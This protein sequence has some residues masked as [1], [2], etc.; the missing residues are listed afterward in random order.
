MT[1]RAIRGVVLALAILTLTAVPASAATRELLTTF[2]ALEEPAG[3]AVDLETGNV[4]VVE[5]KAHVIDVFGATGGAPADGVPAQIPIV[6]NEFSRGAPAGVAVDNACYEHEPRLT[7]RACEEYDPAY[8]DVYIADITSLSSTGG[9]KQFKL[10]QNHEY[11]LVDEFLEEGVAVPAGLTVDSRGNLYAADIYHGGAKPEFFAPV[12]EFKKTIEKIANGS[13]EEYKEKREELDIPQTLESEAGYVALDDAGDLYVSDEYEFGGARE[14]YYGVA[15]LTLNG[16]GGVSAEAILAGNIEPSHRPVAVDRA[17]GVV[18]VG[19]GSYIAEYDAAGALLST[20]GSTQALG[21]SLGK[22]ANSAIAVAVNSVSGNVYVA[23]PLHGDVDV[24]GPA[25]AP[26]V[27]GAQQPAAS[28]VSRTSALVAGSV[29]PESA[30][31]NYYFEYVDAG[32]YEPGA[33]DP[34]V[35]GGRTALTPLPG[36]HA[37]ETVERVV[38]SGLLPGTTYDYRM[39]VTNADGTSYGPDETF[40]TASATP[41]VTVTGLAGEVSATSATLSGVVGPRGL[42]TSYVFE[43]G[44]DTSYGGAR[45]FGNAG[46]STGEVPVSISLQ[47]LVPG[48][49][50]HYRLSAT[51]FDG[52]SYGQDGTFT[53]RGVPAGLAQPPATPLIASPV[54]RF[55]AIA[56]ATS[57]RRAATRVALAR[58]RKLTNALRA[59]R[60][61]SPNKRRSCEKQARKQYRKTR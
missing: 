40:T 49:T 22:N 34:Y 43:V 15:K 27:F 12:V 59:C 33:G 53:T 4:Y 60:R 45:L 1:R 23:N 20:F 18:Y 7:G 35:N 51:S 2:G 55:P 13:E 14:K 19:D 42:A 54:V 9:I 8:G 32:E 46:D 57:M 26:A 50:Y 38:L 17:S 21:G 10:N 24:F 39:V 30:T 16:S 52:T 28:S 31:A 29:D 47:Y 41:P 36:G 5:G 37:P 56:G 3:L 25:V 58:A 44:T 11:E 6:S 48:T 61:K